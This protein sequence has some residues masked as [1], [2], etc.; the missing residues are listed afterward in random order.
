MVDE[1]DLIKAA[2]ELFEGRYT[3]EDVERFRKILRKA[4][5]DINIQS[6]LRAAEYLDSLNLVEGDPS[7]LVADEMIGMEIAEY[8][9]GRNAFFNFFR[10][11]TRKP[12]ILSELP[13]FQ[14]DAYGGLIAGCMTRAFQ[15]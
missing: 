15:W 5:K 1:E 9:G 3:E 6:L 2:F 13:P 14:D 11:D 7:Y 12:G 4:M 10:Y 8:I